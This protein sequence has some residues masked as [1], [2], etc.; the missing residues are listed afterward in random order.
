MGRISKS[1][2][3]NHAI[4]WIKDMMK[5]PFV[6]G[7]VTR[8]TPFSISAGLNPVPAKPNPEMTNSQNTLGEPF[9]NLLEQVNISTQI[10][11]LSRNDSKRVKP[12][13][14]RWR[15][16]PRHDCRYL[17]VGPSAPARGRHDIDAASITMSGALCGS[18]GA[19]STKLF[20][21]PTSGP[22]TKLRPSRHVAL[23]L[24]ERRH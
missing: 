12:S 7:E 22:P 1:A 23:R 5:C 13:R 15:G 2:A 19:I 18:F 17:S 21:A 4:P 10:F 3:M 14:F 16:C 24:T 6:N 8:A 11:G 20:G 9:G